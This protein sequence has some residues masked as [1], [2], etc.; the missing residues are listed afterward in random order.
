MVIDEI[1][2]D[3]RLRHEIQPMTPDEWREAVLSPFE[4]DDA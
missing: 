3:E 4:D 2:N 1:A